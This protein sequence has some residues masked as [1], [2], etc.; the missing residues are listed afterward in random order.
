[1]VGQM[2]VDDSWWFMKKFAML[3][4][5]LGQ[6]VNTIF[7]AMRWLHHPF[8]CLLAHWFRESDIKIF[9][10]GKN[11]CMDNFKILKLQFETKKTEF[12]NFNKEGSYR[13]QMMRRIQIWSQNLN[14]TIFDHLLGEKWSKTGFCQFVTTSFGQKGVKYCPILILTPE[15][16]SSHHLQPLWPLLL[17]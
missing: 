2:F 17:K 15:L 6:V 12:Q 1:M 9:E 13:Q 11:D 8:Q 10:L 3:A 7:S 14:Q 16:K 4:V 5:V